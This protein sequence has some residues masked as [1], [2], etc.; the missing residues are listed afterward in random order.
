MTFKISDRK[1]RPHQLRYFIS[2]LQGYGFRL[3]KHGDSDSALIAD[4]KNKKRGF[5]AF[6]AEGHEADPR[7]IRISLEA[8][9]E[10]F[11]SLTGLAKRETFKEELLRLIRIPDSQNSCFSFAMLDLDF[12]KK[13]NDA[14]GHTTGDRVLAGFAGLLE[15]LLDENTIA[16][17]YGGEEFL[18]FNRE[19]EKV[20]GTNCKLEQLRRN[21]L[22]H[23]FGIPGGVNFSAGVV[24]MGFGDFSAH[25]DLFF[26]LLEK[27]DLALYQAKNLG[28]GRTVS[29]DD[30][31]NSGGRI[32]SR[33]PN[34]EA[35]I[36]FGRRHGLKMGECFLVIDR[37]LSGRGVVPGTKGDIYPKR[38]KG[39]IYVPHDPGS[40]QAET[41]VVSI[42]YELRDWPVAVG[43]LLE[44]K[45]AEPPALKGEIRSYRHLSEQTLEWL[46]ERL[47]EFRSQGTGITVL[48][49]SDAEMMISS[50]GYDV[51]TEK[52]GNL[53]A[54]WKERTHGDSMIHHLDELVFWGGWR[55]DFEL[56]MFG[57][58]AKE[59]FG[60]SFFGLAFKPE[61]IPENFCE[62]ASGIMP[63]L[64][65][66]KIWTYGPDT[67]ESAGIFCL[68]NARYADGAVLLE[69]AVE[70]GNKSSGIAINLFTAYKLC[71]KWE[72]A[73]RVF[74][75]IQAE[76][77]DHILLGMAGEVFLFLKNN[78]EAEKMFHHSIELKPDYENSLNNLAHLY[79]EVYPDDKHRLKKALQ[80]VKKALSAAP[81]HPIFLE[82]R[83]R[84]TELLGRRSGD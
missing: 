68:K 81:D 29:F 66:G 80:M 74:Q 83:D 4:C 40:L 50:Q 65:K 41:T 17:R 22:G 24:R 82:T 49:L 34:H 25:E 46:E 63:F 69:K 70:I 26:L 16:G 31:M 61:I 33:L 53:R 78:S 77:H 35:I 5:H 75:G 76:H 13:I 36:N 60:N 44:H 3:S 38:V 42:L 18:F 48:R 71:K 10:K 23:D 56:G 7:F 15:G 9:F 73:I 37:E 20:T 30:L 58:K 43:D 28:R 12:F 32:V 52:V 1:I 72:D 47:D 11:D 54:F 55:H 27:A 51:F 14:Y 45:L 39:E 2:F 67:L 84:I 57:R 64:E 6:D 79:C 62:A 19:P 59:L 8:L 21:C